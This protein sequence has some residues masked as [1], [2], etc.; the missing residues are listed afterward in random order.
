[1]KKIFVLFTALLTMAPVF[2]QSDDGE[3][4]IEWET[5]SN[6]FFLGPKVGGVLTTMGDPDGIKLYDGAGV[7]F[8]AGVAMKARFGKA[9][10]ESEGGTGY[11]GVGLELKYKLNAVKTFG[12]DQDG[13]EN[14]N[15]SLSYFEVPIYAQCYPFATSS[16]MSNFY[17][18]VGASIAGTMSSS[19]DVLV[20]NGVSIKTGDLKGYDVRPIVGLG[21]TIPKTGFDIN[22]RYYIGTSDLA[23]NFKCKMSSFEVSL[24][25]LFDI[26]QF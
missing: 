6:T 21:Y 13:K 7:G 25:W 15:L 23:K 3:D 2:A 12:T 1:M 14:A 16:S 20:A 4:E 9:S 8:S 18:E 22:A 11:F 17:A 19:P 24:A 26:A 10:A 5:K